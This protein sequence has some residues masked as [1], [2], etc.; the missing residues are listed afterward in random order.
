MI[1]EKRLNLLDKKDQEKV[2]YFIKLL[3]MQTKYN[4]LKKEIDN[5]KKE[6]KKSET[7][8]HDDIWSNLNV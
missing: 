3:T 2:E 7:L 1:D 4:F 6:I 5:R 8:T